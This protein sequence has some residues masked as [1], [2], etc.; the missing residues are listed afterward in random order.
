MPTAQ[1][2]AYYYPATP[3]QKRKGRAGA[4]ELHVIDNGDRQILAT[5]PCADKRE[6]RQLAADHHARPWNF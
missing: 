2:A 5:R 4:F 3:A 1:L 6:A